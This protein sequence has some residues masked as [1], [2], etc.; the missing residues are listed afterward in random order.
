MVGVTGILRGQNVTGV[1]GNPELKNE[2]ETRQR[3]K[4]VLRAPEILEMDIFKDKGV[5]TLEGAE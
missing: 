2:K 3:L 4:Y 5:F 1:L